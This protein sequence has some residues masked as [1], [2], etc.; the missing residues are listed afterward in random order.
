MRC[1]NSALLMI[2]LFAPPTGAEPETGSAPADDL[3]A[4]QG[5]WKVTA[6]YWPSDDE[7]RLPKEARL[8]QQGTVLVIDGNRITQD[9]RTVATLANDLSLVAQEKEVGFAGNRLLMLTLPDGKGLLCSYHLKAGKVQIAYSHN[10]FCHRGS[11]QVVY[12]ERPSK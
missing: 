1:A 4:L 10:C 5:R 9:G 7:R 3:K 12:L 8:N 11:G 6:I 2:V